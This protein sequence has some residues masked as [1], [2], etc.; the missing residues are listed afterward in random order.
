M[1]REIYLDLDGVCIDFITAAVKAQGLDHEEIFSQWERNYR[2]VYYPEQLL[3]TDL[4]SFWD[5]IELFGESFWVN[6]KPYPWF[7][8]LYQQLDEVGHVIF[9]TASTLSPLPVAEV[10]ITL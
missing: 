1:S 5:K 9:C 7:E 10:A 4:L 2:G 3:M 6:L 8:R